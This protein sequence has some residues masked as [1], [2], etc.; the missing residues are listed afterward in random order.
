MRRLPPLKTLPAFELSATRASISAAAEELRLTH[1]AVSRQIKSLEDHLGVALFRR[2][3]RRIELTAA[4]A[5]LLPAVRQAMQV[6]ETSAARVAAHTRQGPLTVSC[7]ATFMMRWLIPRL[8]AFNAT[9]PSIEV[10]LSASHAPVSFA[11][12]GTDVAIRLGKPPWPRGVAAYP[13]LADHV[14][15]VLAPA[16]LARHRIKRPADLGRVA[17]LHADTRPQAWADWQRLAG[18]D[19]LDPAKGPRFEHTYFLLEAA[20]SGLGAAIGSYPLVQHDLESGRLVA[21]FGFVVSGNAYCL[22]HPRR[23][24]SLEKTTA[25]RAWIKAQTRHGVGPRQ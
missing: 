13:F 20:V 16:L 1:G 18:A 3:N 4:G 5:E 24:P 14:G 15:P 6:L 22:L 25:F 7:L 10:R 11:D 19:G 23:T 17:L 9:H 21:P 2:F 12:G 8:Y